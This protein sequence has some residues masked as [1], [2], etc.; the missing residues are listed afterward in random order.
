MGCSGME[1]HHQVHRIAPV[2]QNSAAPSAGEDVEAVAERLQRTA[3]TAVNARQ[4]AEAA[5][6]EVTALRSSRDSLASEVAALRSQLALGGPAAASKAVSR[7]HC[8]MASSA[9]AD[10]TA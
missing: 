8:V 1:L 6:A 9:G 5:S 4:Q 7:V 3:S 2:R 10:C